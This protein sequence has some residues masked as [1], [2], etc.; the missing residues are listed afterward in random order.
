MPEGEEEEVNI[1]KKVT[2]VFDY[3]EDIERFGKTMDKMQRKTL[4]KEETDSVFITT[5]NVLEVLNKVKKN[6]ALPKDIEN[7]LKELKKQATQEKTLLGMEEFDIFGGIG[8]DSTKVSKINNKKHR[9]I[10]KDRFNI[11]DI[12]KNTKQIGYK[13]ALEKT[14]ENVKKA[15][16]KTVVTED[17]PVYKAIDGEKLDAQNINVFNINPEN[18]IKETLKNDST[19]INF[20]KINLKE[21]T[22]AVSYSNIIFYDNQNKTLPVGQDLSTKI[23]ID[24]SKM[25]LELKEKKSFKIVD[26]EDNQDDFSKINIKNITV[27]EYDV[28]KENKE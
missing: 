23:L 5:T 19:K 10:K 16:S 20:Y 1:I 25:N 15:I 22:N 14:I 28:I 27:F 13:L 9:E 21:G 6:I 3:E 12:T 4:S 18:E 8:Q 26:M 17:L 24:V 7:N 11:L 2:K